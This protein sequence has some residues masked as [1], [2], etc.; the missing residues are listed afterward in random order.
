MTKTANY[1]ELGKELP[2][3]HPSEA[4]LAMLRT[5]RSTPADFMAGPGPDAAA[6][7]DILKIAARVPDHRRV[8]PFR[9]VVFEREARTQFGEILRQAFIAA[10]PDADDVKA[11][12][13]E[14]RFLRAPTVIA[15]ISSPDET[16]RTPLW[17][18][19][20]CVG[21][22]CQ[23]MLLAASAHGFAAQW[24]TEWYAFE[25]AVGRAAG[26]KPHERFAGFVYIGT[27]TEEPKERGRPDMASIVSRYGE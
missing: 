9:F 16:H 24:L 3:C 14:G 6:L 4:T 1:P 10:N 5:R 18:Q 12:F 8:V 22:V 7:D 21:A 19:Q 23:N 15:V 27:A 26:L 11:A 13:E 17:E 2:S 25:D 20:L